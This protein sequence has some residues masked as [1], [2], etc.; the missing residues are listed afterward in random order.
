M[1]Q[2][3]EDFG[4]QPLRDLG[5]G[6]VTVGR[7]GAGRGQVAGHLPHGDRVAGDRRRERPAVHEVVLSSTMAFMESVT[8]SELNRQ[9]ARVLERVKAGES[10]EISEYGRPVARI[11]PAGPTTGVPLLDRLIA[12]GRAVPAS[13]HGPIPPT[14]PRDET[15]ENVSLSAALAQLRDDERY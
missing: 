1:A 13:N 5:G 2:Q 8:V 9:T 11:T 6:G 12:Q 3:A 10:V 15:D 4:V 14:P 7:V